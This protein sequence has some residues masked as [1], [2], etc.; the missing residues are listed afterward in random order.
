[1]RLDG[2]ESTQVLLPLITLAFAPDA[3]QGAVIGNGSGMSSH[4]LLGSRSLQKLVTIDIEPEM[5][6]GSHTFYP[7]NRRVF[8]DPRSQFVHDDAKS[9]FAASNRKFDLILSEPSNP[10]VSGVSGL[11]TDEFYQRIRTYLTPA[12]VFGQW[13]H[14]YEIDDDLVLGVIKAVHRNF[15]SY[16]IFLTADVDVLIVASNQPAL[17]SPDWSVFSLPDIKKDLA[18]F[19]PITSDALESARLVSRDVLVPLIGAGEGANSDFY[20]TLDLLAE[21][22]RYMKEFAKGFEGLNGGSFDI[23]VALAGRRILPTT[24]TTPPLDIG[25]INNLALGAR[26]RGGEKLDPGNVG[27]GDR[28][29]RDAAERAQ[30]LRDLMAASHPPADWRIF[31]T[32]VSDVENDRHAGTMGWADEAWFS[33]VTRFLEQ[34]HAP[35]DGRAALRFLHAIAS[36]DW[37]VAAAQVDALQRAR[38][39]GVA[40]INSDLLREAGTVAL[41]RTGD[42]AKARKLLDGMA[43]FSTRKSGDLRVRLLQAHVAAQEGR[44]KA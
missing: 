16:E 18:H 7:V 20:P 26:L 43:E 44:P 30:T 36:Y 34:Q 29:F 21:R 37:P 31:F 12:G 1:M 10:W 23:G 4:L 3:K 35:D 2:D 33:S 15:P 39:Q 8:D 5:I 27:P 22:T 19:L 24:G 28:D 40:W 6:N 17:P 13:L 32:R 25:R 41:L 11:F 38:N 14:L 9:Y 42:V